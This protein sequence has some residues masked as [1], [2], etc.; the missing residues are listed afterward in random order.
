M[1]GHAA[2]T[3]FRYRAGLRIRLSVRVTRNCRRSPGRPQPRADVR[4]HPAE[5]FETTDSSGRTACV[6]CHTNNTA[7]AGLNLNHDTVRSARQCQRGRENG[8][9]AR[10]SE[11]FANSFLY[12]KVVGAAGIVGRRMPQNGPYLSD[13]QISSSVG[14]RPALQVT[15]RSLSGAE[16]E[17]CDTTAMDLYPHCWCSACCWPRLARARSGRRRRG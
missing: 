10:G 14:S 6:T 4:E 8:G 9:Q 7:P 13:G 12:Q 17:S 11:R 1:E 16:G 3:A 5:V 15:R 2:S